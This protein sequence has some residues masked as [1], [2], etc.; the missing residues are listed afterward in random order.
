MK[1]DPILEKIKNDIEKS[2]P[3]ILN[4]IDLSSIKIDNTEVISPQNNKRRLTLKIMIPSLSFAFLFLLVFSFMY[5]PTTTIINHNIK[6]TNKDKLVANYAVTA[7]DIIGGVNTNTPLMQNLKTSNAK[8]HDVF[9]DHSILMQEYLGLTES[10]VKITESND[11]KYPY[12]MEIRNNDF[13]GIETNYILKYNEKREE[14]D[15]EIEKKMVGIILYENVT[16]D[17]IVDQEQDSE[18]EEINI[19]IKSKSGFKIEIEKEVEL[20]EY[21]VEYKIYQNNKEIKK[22]IFKIED[23][24]MILEIDSKNES[25]K[26]ELTEITKYKYNVKSDKY[27]FILE[28]DLEN[29]TF[30]YS[31]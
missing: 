19:L 16:Y 6:V 26:F 13:Y 25:Y 28:I 23:E 3:N 4:K 21:I 14:D 12:T 17:F 20:D 7:F 24:E 2:T 29:K 11:K 30:I 31:W 5:K 1:K 18:E 22:V 8:Y 27:D 15:D 10:V 9:N